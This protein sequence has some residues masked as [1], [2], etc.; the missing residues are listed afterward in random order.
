[1]TTVSFPGLGIEFTVKKVAVTILGWPIH[2]YAIIITAGLLLA[3]WYITKRA[4]GFG[5]DP[6]RVIDY[7][8]AC[9]AA[10]IVGAR[11]YFVAF[12]WEYYE[13]SLGEVFKTWNGGMAIYGGIIGGV[14]GGLILARILKMKPLPIADMAMG[15]LILAQGIGRWGNFVNVEAF[16]SNTTLPWGM[17][18]PGVVSFLT[19]HQASL[20]EQGIIVDPTVPVHPTFLYESI[21]C[22]LG[23]FVIAWYTSRRRFDGELVLLYSGW[24]GLGRFVIEGLRTD[25]L[26]WGSIRVSQALAG[27]CVLAAIGIWLFIHRRIRMSDDPDC[28][29]PYVK[30]EGCRLELADRTAKVDDNASGYAII[31]GTANEEL[32][33]KERDDDTNGTAN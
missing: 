32:I 28:L 10:G 26:M 6:D 14:V 12:R 25:S 27:L 31:K 17:T 30:T 7:T 13:D 18:G 3:I 19:Y 9:V 20:A 22:I 11:L 4:P 5:V 33:L 15:G 8:M 24:Y 16:G 23:F 1:M 21:W 2:W 29:L